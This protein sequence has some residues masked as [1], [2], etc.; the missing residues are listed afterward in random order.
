MATVNGYLINLDTG[1]VG[2]TVGD[3]YSGSTTASF[4]DSSYDTL[5]TGIVNYP[6]TVGDVF[7]YFYQVGGNYYFVPSDSSGFPP[8]ETGDLTDFAE[9]IYGTTGTD[10]LTGTSDGEYIQDTDQNIYNWTSHDTVYGGGGDDTVSFGDGND[11]IY[12]GDG[13]DQIGS[14]STGQGSNRIY[15]DAG[16]DSIIGGAGDDTIYGGTGDDWLSGA[17]GNDTIYGGD[18]S[19]EIWV[20]DNH[21][22]AIVEG[23]EGGV[24]WDIIGFS[25]YSSTQGVTVTFTGSESGTFDFS[26]TSTSGSFRE[27]EEFISTEYAD[28]IDASATSQDLLVSTE[29]GD[30][31]LTGGTGDDTLYGGDGGDTFSGGAGSDTLFGGDGNDR[32]TIEDDDGTSTISGGGWWDTIEFSNVVSTQGVTVTFT[33][34]EVG[35]YDFN[36]TAGTGTFDDIEEIFGTVDY[37]DTI[38]A[39]AD[40]LGTKVYTFGGDDSFIG[41]SGAD[42]VYLEDGDDSAVGGAG[43]DA[44]YGGDGSDTLSGGAGDDTLSGGAGD[45]TLSGGAGDDVYVFEDGS[46]HDVITDFDTSDSDGDGST[47]DQLDLSLLT[48]SGGNPVNTADVVVS[49]DGSGNA[50]LTFPIGESITLNGVSPGSATP[51]A[52]VSMGVPCFTSGTLIRTPSGDRL[53]ETLRHGDLVQTADHGAQPISWAGQTTLNKD[54]L[55]ANPKARPVR[56]AKGA[57]GNTRDL[58]VSRQHGIFVSLEGQSYLARAIHLARHG[59][60]GFRV[61]NGV[62]KVT[63]VHLMF[64]QHQILFAENCPSESFYPGPM[65]LA[66]LAPA[67]QA[68]ILHLFPLLK[69][70]PV[71]LAAYGPSARPFIEA[72]RLS[73]MSVMPTNTTELVF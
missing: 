72:K 73:R 59:G 70:G 35:T 56:I 14:W 39:S 37:G 42:R 51:S 53:V 40:S 7:G 22:F 48:D 11:V 67:H 46:G 61:A 17:V 16:D 4:D 47:N 27:I 24:D 23:G 13:A 31:S 3:E 41:G 60:D 20:T 5:G 32:F 28:V 2:P 65:G 26:G 58:L 12:G 68:E 18:G 19:D 38:D 9:A 43:N 71:G 50:V 21:Q 30:D 25:N 15:G 33:G 36:G 45:D 29:G 64:A 8:G 55:A 34:D 69:L 44:L 49:D 1:A 10:T 52:L 66:A 62:R 57:L 54:E 63:Y 6:N